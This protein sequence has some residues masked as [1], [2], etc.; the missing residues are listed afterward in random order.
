M[1]FCKSFPKR[2]AATIYRR[3]AARRTG[4]RHAPLSRVFPAGHKI[5]ITITGADPREKD[6]DESRPAPE[7]TI[8]RDPAHASYVTLPVV[9]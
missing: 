6:R 7:V 9:P 3:R 2:L 8:L 4:F 1:W 5:R